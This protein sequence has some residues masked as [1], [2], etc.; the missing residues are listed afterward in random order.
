M[1]P[2]HWNSDKIIAHGLAEILV[3][4]GKLLERTEKT[5]HNQEKFMALADDFK[6]ALDKLQADVTTLLGKVGT[7]SGT[8]DATLQPLL[9][10]V[11]ALDATVVAGTP[12]P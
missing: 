5:L 4:Q 11:N 6:T 1:W 8:P 9:D 2:D 3:N 12:T 10:Q 7:P